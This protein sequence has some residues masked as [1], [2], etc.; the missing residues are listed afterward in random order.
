MDGLGVYNVDAGKVTYYHLLLGYEENIFY[1]AVLDMIGYFFIQL[2]A[3]TVLVCIMSTQERLPTTYYLDTRKIFFIWPCCTK[4]YSYSIWPCCK[5]V[6]RSSIFIS[7]Q[8]FISYTVFSGKWI[9]ILY[10]FNQQVHCWFW[11]I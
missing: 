3:W 8:Q 1:L 2:H 6:L 11:V 9:W 4:Y 5:K 10:I 7:Q